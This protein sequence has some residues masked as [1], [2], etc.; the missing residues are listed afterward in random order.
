MKYFLLLVILIFFQNCTK[1]KTVLVCGDHVCINKKEAGQYFE[2]NLSIEVKI[3]DNKEKL[4]INLV[5]LNLNNITENKKKIS[6]EQKTTTKQKVKIL[7]SDEILIIKKE[8]IKKEKKKKIV[9]KISNKNIKKKELSI[10][11]SKIPEINSGKDNKLDNVKK[12]EVSK[13]NNKKNINKKR[14][15]IVDICEI[16]KK[17]NIDE[18]AKFLLKQGNKKNYPDITT[19]E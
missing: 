17:C 7:T 1:P 4:N 15:E 19:R 6:I 18:I 5:E 14:I 3:I 13:D 12:V 10:K 8:I 11:K 16:I 2:E 9:K